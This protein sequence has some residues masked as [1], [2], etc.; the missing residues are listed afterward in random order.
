MFVVL[1]EKHHSNVA[2]HVVVRNV[3]TKR[4]VYLVL[5]LTLMILLTM[6]MKMV[7]GWNSATTKTNAVIVVM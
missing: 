4:T 3:Q 5:L 1:V 7:L 6:M 2:N